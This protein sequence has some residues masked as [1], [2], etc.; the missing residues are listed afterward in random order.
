MPRGNPVVH[1][2][3]A[4][5]YLVTDSGVRYARYRTSWGSGDNVFSAWNSDA[6]QAGLSLRGVIAYHPLPKVTS[7][8]PLPEG[9]GI[10]WE[11][12]ASTLRNTAGDL[13]PAHF[14]TVEKCTNLLTSAFVEVTEMSTNR[15][16]VIPNTPDGQAFYRVKLRDRTEINLSGD[17]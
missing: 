9:L 12:P 3:I 4:Y 17:Q 16:A 11:G 15:E 6:W 7:I 1:G 13:I 14:Y 8:T 10:K 5:G 2:M